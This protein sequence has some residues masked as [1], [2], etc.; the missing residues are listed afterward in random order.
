MKFNDRLLSKITVLILSIVLLI[1]GVPTQ[2]FALNASI[3]SEKPLEIVRESVVDEESIDLPQPEPTIEE[4]PDESTRSFQK[5]VKIWKSKNSLSIIYEST[6]VLQLRCAIYN[7][8][9]G[10]LLYTGELVWDNNNSLY[11]IELDVGTLFESSPSDNKAVDTDINEI[12]LKVLLNDGVTRFEEIIDREIGYTEITRSEVAENGDITFF[13]QPIESV[14]GYIIEYKNNEEICCFDIPD[15]YIDIKNGFSN[16]STLLLTPYSIENEVKYFGEAVEYDLVDFNNLSESKVNEQKEI[17]F[18]QE[19]HEI[20][21]ESDIV[22]VTPNGDSADEKSMDKNAIVPSSDNSDTESENADIYIDDIVEPQESISIEEWVGAGVI[23]GDG[24]RY[25]VLLLDNSG[26][27][28]GTPLSTEKAAAK[29]FCSQMLAADGVNYISIVTYSDHVIKTYDFTNQ[30]NDI[31][32]QLNNMSASGG[33]NTN[34]ALKQATTLLNEAPETATKNIVLLSDGLP[35]TGDT[36]TEGRYSSKDSYNYYK[37]A[38]A[39]YKTAKAI[40]SS[41][42]LYSLGFFHVLSGGDL[43]FARRLMSDLP[44]NE[45][46]YY[47]V[48][49]VNDLEFMFGKIADDIT[50]SDLKKLYI[51]QH[52]SYINSSQYARDIIPGFGSLLSQILLDIREDSNVKKYNVCQQIS[53]TINYDLDLT[54]EYEILLANLMIN[55]QADKGIKEA[56]LSNLRAT[57]N[58]TLE[59]VLKYTETISD[60]INKADKN[61]MIDLYNKMMDES[62]LS[63]SYCKLYDEYIDTVNE[64]YSAADMK[65]L[66]KKS[67][68]A[69]NIADVVLATASETIEYYCFAQAYL[70]TTDDFIRTLGYLY[71]CADIHTWDSDIEG[72]GPV[73]QLVELAELQT[74]IEIFI[75]EMEAYKENNADA[76]ARFAIN[77]LAYKTESKVANEVTDK[78]L[79]FLSTQIPI[80][81]IIPILKTGLKAGLTIVDI[82]SNLDDRA[83][84]GNMVEKLYIISTLMDEVVEMQ[85]SG[86]RSEYNSGNSDDLLFRRAAQFDEAVNIY[87]SSLRLAANYGEEYEKSLLETESKKLIPSKEKVAWYSAAITLANVDKLRTNNILCHHQ[88]LVYNHKSDIVLDTNRLKVFTIACPVDVDVL[89]DQ[90]K[91]VA[92]LS[93]QNTVVEENYAPYFF[94]ISNANNEYIKVVVLPDSSKFQI[95]LSGT[96]DGKMDVY[97]GAYDGKE[98]YDVKKYSGITVEENDQGYLSVEEE[99]GF[100]KLIFNNIEY[101]EDDIH[102]GYQIVDHDAADKAMIT[103]DSSQY[104]CAKNQIFTIHALIH[105]PENFENGSRKFTGYIAMLQNWSWVQL[106]AWY[107]DGGTI[108]VD[109]PVKVGDLSTGNITFTVSL[110][111]S[112]NFTTG[113]S[114]YDCLFRVNIL[115]DSFKVTFDPDGGSCE[116]TYKE[117]VYGCSYG[118]LPIPERDGY[119]FNGWFTEREGKGDRIS[120]KNT[121]EAIS[122]QQVY[123]YWITSDKNSILVEFDANGGKTPTSFRCF[124]D[125]DKYGVLPIPIQEG[126]RFV[127]WYTEKEGGNLVDSNTIV[128]SQT[129][130][131]HWQTLEIKGF[132]DVQDPSH[133]FYKAIYWA[134]DAG[135]TKGYPDG[136]F[137][138]DRSCTRGEMI[139]FLWR[140]AGKPAPKALSKSPFKDVPKNHAF[141]SAIIWASQKGITK[142]YPDG[143]F[144]INRNVSRGECMMFLWRLKGKSAPKAVSVSPFK[145]VPKTHAFYNAILWGAQKKITNGYTSGPKKGTFGINENCT[146]GAIVTFLYRAK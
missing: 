25:T 3:D 111:Y 120:A 91:R 56:Y 82:F 44:A 105:T 72:I 41:W 11:K 12:P 24:T 29:K 32:N 14:T 59:L 66:V 27:M 136:T 21:K 86:L 63:D 68:T 106:G 140:Y 48:T 10:D 75:G 60:R 89:D 145:D 117:I 9:S 114:L 30:Y 124:Y 107:I 93:A 113:A 31:E 17:S 42:N 35:Q 18:Y 126:S 133:A 33:T 26:S 71:Y 138:I 36:F 61:R 131:A 40:D 46:M 54:Q 98:I 55:D 85:E 118:E 134:A 132:S 76:L 121:V 53:K 4:I 8:V 73:T 74:A 88:G 99:N 127:G 23:P 103:T 20:A 62:F 108:S 112:D 58:D 142:G 7:W 137:G 135:I 64:Y 16:D 110:F 81:K 130:Y 22:V 65:S 95:L 45:N 77:K 119:S 13:W 69:L 100:R 34:A 143:T 6:D 122:D 50:L 104:Y 39:V 37:Y 15:N 43:S 28:S 96:G 49:D 109:L 67:K 47:E 128:R 146:R 38:N 79:D 129:L 57:M 92:H 84:S 1:G 94:T 123:A 102:S 87:K 52:V 19:E 115:P 90:G 78:A 101:T 97:L 83:A 141:Y 144:G 51:E 80:F 70:D 116:K 2:V 125:G 5:N 139:M